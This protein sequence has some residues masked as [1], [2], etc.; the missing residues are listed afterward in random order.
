MA[1]QWEATPNASFRIGVPINEDGDI[2]QSGE[3]PTGTKNVTFGYVSNSATLVHLLTGYEAG[4][5]PAQNEHSGLG[6]VFIEFLLGGSYTQ[7]TARK[8]VTYK[9]EEVD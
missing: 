9:A 6:G 1:Y 3:T 7:S 8:S 4:T 2:A 5:S